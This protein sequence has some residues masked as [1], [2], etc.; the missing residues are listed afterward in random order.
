M[1]GGGSTQPNEAERALATEAQRGFERGDLDLC[2]SKL[3][4][5]SISGVSSDPALHFD[6][7]VAEFIKSGCTRVDEFKQAL[8]NV[9]H[10]LNV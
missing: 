6:K 7:A 9:A 4:A 3:Q 10:L 1:S 8:L 2:L 5:L